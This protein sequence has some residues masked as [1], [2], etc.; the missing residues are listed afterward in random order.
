MAAINQASSRGMRAEA[1]N[2]TM[3]Q[4]D[5]SAELISVNLALHGPKRLSAG[6]AGKA[7]IRDDLFRMKRSSLVNEVHHALEVQTSQSDIAEIL[8]DFAHAFCIEPC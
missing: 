4:D 8:L 6:N 2:P 5:R 7:L 3:V 1:H